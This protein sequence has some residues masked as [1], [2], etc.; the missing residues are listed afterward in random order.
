MQQAL[1][2]FMKTGFSHSASKYRALS[3]E[4]NDECDCAIAF[5][6]VERGSL[7]RRGYCAQKGP[8]GH[9]HEHVIDLQNY[10]RCSMDANENA[11]PEPCD[12]LRILIRLLRAL[13]VYAKAKGPSYGPVGLFFTLSLPDEKKT[14]IVH[15]TL[16]RMFFNPNADVRPEVRPDPFYMGCFA[17]RVYLPETV[18]LGG[19]KEDCY[20]LL[21]PAE[22]S[23]WENA[24]ISPGP[25]HKKVVRLSLADEIIN[26]RRGLLLT[27]RHLWFKQ[28]GFDNI[29]EGL[30]FA[31]KTDKQTR[32]L[33]P[34][35]VS[36]IQRSQAGRSRS[37]SPR[38][39][40]GRR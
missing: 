37:R 28:R 1:A 3:S 27:A 9:I 25:E 2:R 40:Q 21:I 11:F 33:V 17:L 35:S 8:T 13:W 38:Q 22:Y 39:R 23:H 12:D 18:E 34:K 6:P 31:L 19:R 24:R 36:E 5:Q 10:S 26:S 30:V 32:E 7:A 20:E 14:S 29:F 16:D 15:F 4:F